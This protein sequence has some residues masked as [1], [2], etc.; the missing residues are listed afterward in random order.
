MAN[1]LLLSDYLKRL[2]LPVIKALYQKLAREAEEHNLSYEDYLLALLEE[3]TIVREENALR[4]RIRQ[5]R[6]PYLKTLDSF[7][8]S[9]CQIEKHKV[10]EL[11]QSQYID[12]KENVIFLGEPGL[13]K[14][15]LS[16]ALSVEA[17]KKGYRVLFFT[18]T[19]LI[20]EMNEAKEK[21]SLISL[22]KKLLRAQ[23]VLVD[24]LGF[25]PFDKTGA[26]FLFEFFS[27]RYE[28]GSLI[29]TSNLDF[30]HWTEVFHDERLT[31]A[32]LDRVTH[33]AHIIQ[34]KGE[35]YRLR[36]SLAQYQYKL[37]QKGEKET[38]EKQSVTS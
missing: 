36:Q 29:I 1:K 12:Q 16:V 38:G 17:C 11:A 20:N 10:I 27:S 33:H 18:A 14:T 5:A 28:Q 4:R 21:F 32:L 7:D 31:G 35:S 15:H 2:R 34:I 22:E 3:E 23:L 19:G 30:S 37:S 9:V 25:V 13:G 26:Q 8:F 6:F 24:E